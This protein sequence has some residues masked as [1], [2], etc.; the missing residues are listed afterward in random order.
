[1]IGSSCSDDKADQGGAL[2]ICTPLGFFPRSIHTSSIAAPLNLLIAG[3]IS[4]TYTHVTLALHAPLEVKTPTQFVLFHFDPLTLAT[5][6]FTNS[7][8]LLVEITSGAI[9]ECIVI[10]SIVQGSHAE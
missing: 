7:T 4:G 9:F 3:S 6:V 2:H 5:C 1:M 8:G 10:G